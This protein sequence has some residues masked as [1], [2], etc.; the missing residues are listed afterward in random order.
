MIHFSLAHSIAKCWKWHWAEKRI[1]VLWEKKRRVLEGKQR[2]IGERKG[3]CEREGTA[4]SAGKNG[5]VGRV[6]SPYTKE[7]EYP[8]WEVSFLVG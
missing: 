8:Y 6:F 4:S 2:S 3:T 7:G 5:V 1:S